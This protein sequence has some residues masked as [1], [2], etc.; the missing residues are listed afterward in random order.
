MPQHI[1]SDNGPEF[2]AKAVRGWIQGLGART[3]FIEPGSPWE[4]GSTE[5]RSTATVRVSE[6]PDSGDSWEA[7]G[8]TD[9]RGDLL[10]AQGGTS[11]D[12]TVEAR[13]QRLHFSGDPHHQ[14]A[15]LAWLPPAGTRD[16]DPGNATVKPCASVTAGDYPATQPIPCTKIAIGTKGGGGSAPCATVRPDYAARWPSRQLPAQTEQGT[17][18]ALLL[19]LQRPISPALDAPLDGG[20]LPGYYL[21]AC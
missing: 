13:V 4:R 21:G 17:P 15:Q 19:Q 16:N 11:T 18:A 2:A 7:Q 12:G 14:A 3:L 5:W 20:D 1:R 10:H 8:R 9:R 6:A